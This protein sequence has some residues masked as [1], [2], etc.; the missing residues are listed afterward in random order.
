MFGL[1]PSSS[2]GDRL[3]ERVSALEQALVQLAASRGLPS[4][5]VR[6]KSC[7]E[8]NTDAVESVTAELKRIAD[9]F[10]PP[11]PDKVG[12]PYVAQRLGCT[13]V[14]ITEMVRSGEIPIACVV[15]GTGCGKPWKFY[16]VR[17]DE[18]LQGR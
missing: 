1:I 18:W 5:E 2:T 13:T 11:P 16:R 14:W 7:D 4:A 3:A 6:R 8:S 17:I 12:T 10:D 9:H 15:P